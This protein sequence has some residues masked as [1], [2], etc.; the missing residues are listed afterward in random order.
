MR[1]DDRLRQSDIL[2]ALGI[3]ARG[4]G[5]TE[6]R[7]QVHAQATV[8]LSLREEHH[9]PHGFVHGGVLCTL[10]HQSAGAAA[11]SRVRVPVMPFVIVLSG[12]G[13]YDYRALL[14][15]A[16]IRSYFPSTTSQR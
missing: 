9:G 8:G 7:R 10:A 15:R 11:Y 14:T 4:I 3:P 13:L 12:A 16:K 5:L 1:A 6:G 2:A